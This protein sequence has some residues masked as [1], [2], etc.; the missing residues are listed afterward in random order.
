MSNLVF[1]EKGAKVI[2][3]KPIN[4]PNSQYKL[5]SEHK[6]L[7]Y[8]LIETEEL[9]NKNNGDIH[10]DIKTLESYLWNLN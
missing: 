2:E 4:H 8:S 1:S 5:I 10:L 3:I 7:N 6:K 9:E